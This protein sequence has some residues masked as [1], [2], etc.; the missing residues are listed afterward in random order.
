MA[1]KIDR[2]A[3]HKCLKNKKVTQKQQQIGCKTE[4]NDINCY[5]ASKTKKNKKKERESNMAVVLCITRIGKARGNR[6][7]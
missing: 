1:K 6:R 4:K 5:K 7:L 2:N 3:S